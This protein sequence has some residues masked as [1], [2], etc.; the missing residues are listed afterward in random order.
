MALNGPILWAKQ[1]ADVG[2]TT[3]DG[4]GGEAYRISDGVLSISAYQGADGKNHGGNIQSTSANQAYQGHQIVPGQL[5]LTCTG[6]YWEA[7]IRFPRAQGTWGAF[8]LLTPD[9]PVNRG[10]L[11]VD[12]IEYYGLVD[13]RGH[14]HG[15]HRWRNGNSSGDL[16]DYT[17]MDAIADFEWHTYGID[18]RGAATLDGK[19]ALVIYFDGREVGRLAADADYFSSPFYYLLTLT[20]NP[21]DKQWTVP[22]AMEVDFVRV[23]RPAAAQGGSF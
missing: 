9:N 6:C 11:E 17:G 16:G 13:K 23:F 18:L 4:P 5:G 20:L 21:K 7:R 2:L 14:H 12:G 22:Q 1:H 10:H 15:V 3:F 19:P 8:W